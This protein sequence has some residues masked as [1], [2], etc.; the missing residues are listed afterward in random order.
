MLLWTIV[1][2]HS[3]QPV[4]TPLPVEQVNTGQTAASLVTNVGPFVLICGIWVFIMFGLTPMRSRRSYQKDPS[5]QGQFTVNITPASI[6]T[7]N[8]VGTSS[9]TGWNIY[10]YWREGKNVIVLVFLSGTYFI[11]SQAGLSDPQRNELRGILSV[12]LPKK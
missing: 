7:Q 4:D 11:L 2:R 3:Q 8:A 9:Q 6:S 1:Q 10:E 12:A 5:M